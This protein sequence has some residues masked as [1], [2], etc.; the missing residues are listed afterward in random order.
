M[1]EGSR[2]IRESEIIGF[3]LFI[4]ERTHLIMLIRNKEKL[5]A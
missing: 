1:E 4:L 5:A 2:N 3:L